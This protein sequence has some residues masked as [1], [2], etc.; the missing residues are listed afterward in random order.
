MLVQCAIGFDCTNQGA[1]ETRN[2]AS[3]RRSEHDR[4][5]PV[6]FVP[7]RTSPPRSSGTACLGA[8]HLQAS[9]FSRPDKAMTPRALELRERCENYRFRKPRGH[10]PMLDMVLPFW[11][12]TSARQMSVTHC[13]TERCLQHHKPFARAALTTLLALCQPRPFPSLASGRHAWPCRSMSTHECA[14]VAAPPPG[15]LPRIE[16]F[17]ELL[18]TQDADILV[19]RLLLLHGG[20]RCSGPSHGCCCSSSAPSA[21]SWDSAIVTPKSWRSCSRP[22]A[23]PTTSSMCPL[24]AM[25]PRR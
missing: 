1:K 3:R 10:A 13:A 4:G 22:L 19:H 12:L 5:N 15:L 16:L 14:P 11:C 8:A 20:D 7:E 23:E 25:S 9:H 2:H 6:C 24:S 18:S 17:L 21:A